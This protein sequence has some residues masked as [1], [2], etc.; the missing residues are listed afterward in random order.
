MTR[1][2]VT[3]ESIILYVLVSILA[4]ASIGVA[5]VVSQ[6]RRLIFPSRASDISSVA[7]K[8]SHGD[9]DTKAQQDEVLPRDLPIEITA[10]NK[11]TINRA[12]WVS[13]VTGH[14]FKTRNKGQYNV[15]TI[16]DDLEYHLNV[17]SWWKSFMLHTRAQMAGRF[18]FGL[19]FSMKGS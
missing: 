14:V 19:S 2:A 10:S 11:D 1:H 13:R 6:R 12:N 8:D 15:L 16:N 18:R 9:A 7:G 3:P 17:E 4:V 5:V